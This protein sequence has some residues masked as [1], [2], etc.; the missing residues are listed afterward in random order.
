MDQ[1][2]IKK[3]KLGAVGLLGAGGFG[4]L[5]GTLYLL[6]GKA[7]DEKVS[8]AN[9][10]PFDSIPDM[11]ISGVYFVLGAIF[12]LAGTL[13]LFRAYRQPDKIRILDERQQKERRIGL[14]IALIVL[15]VYLLIDALLRDAYGLRY[16]S[17]TQTVIFGLGAAFVVGDSYITL[18]GASGL[19]ETLDKK[20]VWLYGIFCCLFS[21]FYLTEG[22]VSLVA[23]GWMG[24]EN[25]L[26]PYAT[27]FFAGICWLVT[28]VSFLVRML[29]NK[30]EE[31]DEEPEA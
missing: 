31:K 18:R 3:A 1:A 7:L 6:A 2:I 11:V 27:D 5:L 15:V 4:I 23:D 24:S 13:S 25:S 29:L 17:F 20:S 26:S 16:L 9:A 8:S 14:T 12:L 30:K 10:T 28:G 21:A 19:E 22:I